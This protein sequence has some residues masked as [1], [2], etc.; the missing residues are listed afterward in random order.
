M[1]RLIYTMNGNTARE[2]WDAET[3]R[4][5]GVIRRQLLDVAG[6]IGRLPEDVHEHVPTPE[7]QRQAFWD[8]LFG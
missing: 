7:E 4:Q 3:I 2:E 5:Y 6:D 1:E 8:K